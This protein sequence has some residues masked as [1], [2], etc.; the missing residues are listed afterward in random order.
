MKVTAPAGTTGTV[1][2]PLF[3]RDRAVTRDGVPVTAAPRRRLRR[4][5]APVGH[6]RLRV[7]KR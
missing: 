1:A 4:P 7:V 5:A 6:P 2:L 3:G